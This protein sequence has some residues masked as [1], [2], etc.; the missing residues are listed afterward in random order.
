MSFL[1]WKLQEKDSTYAILKDMQHVLNMCIRDV[2]SSTDEHHRA[3]QEGSLCSQVFLGEKDLSESKT[4]IY[5]PNLK[6]P[7]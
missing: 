6:A 1:T 2:H 7:K 4:R 3:F 5:C